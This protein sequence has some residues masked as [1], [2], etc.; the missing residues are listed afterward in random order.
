MKFNYSKK[1]TVYGYKTKKI[2][3]EPVNFSEKLYIF[4]QN[5]DRLIE[6]KYTRSEEWENGVF[7]YYKAVD[8]TCV[9]NIFISERKPWVTGK[10]IYGSIEDA[11]NSKVVKLNNKINNYRERIKHYEKNVEKY[12]NMKKELKERKGV[13]NESYRL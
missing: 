5:S 4:T 6:L 11:V 13:R 9:K 12:Q 7:L 10:G 2:E 8:G 1:E 3:F